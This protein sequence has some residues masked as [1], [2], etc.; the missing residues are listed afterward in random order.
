[1][2]SVLLREDTNRK[3]NHTELQL[4]IPFA[5]AE[6]GATLPQTKVHLELSEAGRDKKKGTPLG[7]SEE[8]HSC[9]SLI[10]N[11]WSPEM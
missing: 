11:F 1:M 5:E 9:H 8:V 7:T 3:R 10:L 4:Q 2:T 6:I